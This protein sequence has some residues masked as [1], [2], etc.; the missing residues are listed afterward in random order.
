[1]DFY[2]YISSYDRI[3]LSVPAHAHLV[4]FHLGQRDNTLPA[5]PAPV[6]SQADPPLNNSCLVPQL[7]PITRVGREPA[8]QM[9]GLLHALCNPSRNSNFT[10]T[11]MHTPRMKCT[12]GFPYQEGIYLS[13]MILHI[14]L[15]WGI[16][17]NMRSSFRNGMQTSVFHPNPI[18]TLLWPQIPLVES[19]L[20]Q[21]PA[22]SGFVGQSGDMLMAHRHRRGYRPLHWEH[23]W[24]QGTWTLKDT[25]WQQTPKDGLNWCWRPD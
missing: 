12:L 15:F 11:H 2:F 9:W 4:R 23:S 14:L 22:I 5:S 25:C 13:H 19:S 16:L 10:Y 17:K 3:F 21:D 8:F 6:G 7:Q 24:L 20:L 1:M 18:V